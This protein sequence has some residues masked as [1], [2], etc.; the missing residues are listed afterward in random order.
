MRVYVLVN[1]LE[2]AEPPPLGTEVEGG[3]RVHLILSQVK[4]EHVQV[5]LNPIGVGGLG[6]RHD[7]PLGLNK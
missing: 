2:L 3:H 6:H 4:V 5:G 7:S 1:V